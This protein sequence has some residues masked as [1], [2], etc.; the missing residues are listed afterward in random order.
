MASH[1]NC[2]LRKINV[3]NWN[4]R[5][6]IGSAMLFWLKL[7]SHNVPRRGIDTLWAMVTSWSHL[8]LWSSFFK[9]WSER[10]LYNGGVEPKEHHA[11]DFLA[12]PSSPWRSTSVKP[13]A[14]RR[15]YRETLFQKILF[16]QET[17][18]KTYARSWS[19][20]LSGL[21]LEADQ[22]TMELQV[23]RCYF[24]ECRNTFYLTTNFIHMD[25]LD[26]LLGA[27]GWIGREVLQ[28][29]CR[30][31]QMWCWEPEALLCLDCGFLQ[32]GLLTQDHSSSWGA[33]LRPVRPHLIQQHPERAE[34]LHSS[35]A[36]SHSAWSLQC[37][38]ITKL[39]LLAV[40]YDK[41]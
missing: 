27:G 9:G 34:K 15:T 16:F 36:P 40:R 13:I 23:Q 7:C 21:T 25:N 29:G 28:V 38:C 8:T 10:L 33:F 11:G 26:W 17:A 19:E 35:L 18:L 41:L 6:V 5:T 39:V 3:N 22:T 4:L 30:E 24:F 2:P 37:C 32:P 14:K 1:E 31:N 12:Q 20:P